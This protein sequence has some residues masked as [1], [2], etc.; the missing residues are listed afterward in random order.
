MEQIIHIIKEIIFTV[1]GL[2]FLYTS[3]KSFRDHT[4]PVNLGTGL[5]WG[6]LGIIFIF[7]SYIPPIIVGIFL[8]L[9]TCL[10]LFKQVKIGKIVEIDLELSRE[11]S[12]KIGNKIFIPVILIGFVALLIA[13]FIPKTSAVSIAFGA[14]ASLIAIRI[15]LKP[16]VT[17]V[18]EHDDRM[19]QQVST[20]GI[21]P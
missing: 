4:N 15:I 14:V 9:I 21:L 10:T 7:G 5:Y 19:V 12:L 3:G 20:T 11:R 16:S 1:I 2:Q 8:M 18:L 6:L 17:E 13:K